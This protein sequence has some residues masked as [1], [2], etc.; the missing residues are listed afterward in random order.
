V[1]YDAGL[2]S[3]SYGDYWGAKSATWKLAPN[4][5]GFKIIGNVLDGSVLIRQH[6]VTQ[7]IGKLGGDLN[8]GSSV[9]ASVYVGAGGSEAG[10]EYSVTLQD[11]LIASGKKIA[12]D[13][14]II[15][16]LINGVWYLSEAGSC[17]VS[18]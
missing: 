13:A 5:D 11:W 3:P 7:L 1:L 9:S 15:A 6:K 12:S 4:R 18:Q 10:S 8:A 14:K 17:T 2:G 16:L